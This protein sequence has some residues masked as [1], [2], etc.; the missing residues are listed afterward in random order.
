MGPVQGVTWLLGSPQWGLALLI[1]N[2]PPMFAWAVIRGVSLYSG[3]KLGARHPVPFVYGGGD[4]A[5]EV[6]TT[7]LG[8]L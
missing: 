2:L 4:A 8:L 6:L 5:P 3:K 1:V 7:N